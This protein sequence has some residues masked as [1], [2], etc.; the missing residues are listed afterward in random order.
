[1]LQGAGNP[2]NSAK[3]AELTSYARKAAADLGVSERTIRQDLSRGKKIDAAVLAEV[4]GTPLDKG[5]AP[6]VLAEVT[7]T[8]LDKGVALDE[9]ARVP[10]ETWWQR[11]AVIANQSLKARL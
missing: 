8:A 10:A 6:D 2:S 9:L 7:G 11:E 1:M 3:S 4:A 5:V